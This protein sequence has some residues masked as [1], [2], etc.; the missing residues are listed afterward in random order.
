MEHIL[1]SKNYTNANISVSENSAEREVCIEINNFGDSVNIKLSKE[2]LHSFIG[3][4]LHV[5]SKIK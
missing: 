3:T 5:Q 4:L 2:E 1:K